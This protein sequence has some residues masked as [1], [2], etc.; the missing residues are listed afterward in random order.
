MK[1]S[2]A[3]LWLLCLS[4]GAGPTLPAAAESQMIRSASGQFSVLAS[5]PTATSASSAFLAESD[6]LRLDPGLLTVSAE[7][8]RQ[9]LVRELHD[10]SPWEG[11]ILFR[12][13]GT[14]SFRAPVEVVAEWQGTGWRYQVSLPEYLARD[15][16]VQALV[17]VDLMEIANRTSA[18]R[19]AEIPAWLTEGL[20]AQLLASR[21]AEL[22][23][24]PP[25]L[26]L[27]GVSATPWVLEQVKYQPLALAHAQLQTNAPLSLEQ[28][29]WPTPESFEGR[30][31]QVYRHC[32]HLLVTRL[33]QLPE[34]PARLHAFIHNLGS[35]YNWQVA[36]LNTY[37]AQFPSLLDFE[38]WW[39]LQVAH[40]TG[41]DLSATYTYSESVQRLREA[42]RFPVEVRLATNTLPMHGE[43]RLQT[44]LEAWDGNRQRRALEQTLTDLALL[45]SRIAPEL[46]ALLDDY[47]LT[48]G[49]YLKQRD[50]AGIYLPKGGNRQASVTLLTRRTLRTLDQL[51]AE[52][53]DL[54]PTP[55]TP[56]A[57]VPSPES[58]PR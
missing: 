35:H 36:F 11:R 51:D 50:R 17:E 40:F 7:R 3:A 19:A 14:D 39:T 53:T 26:N 32:A 41:R 1:A 46:V 58:S 13:R 52:L 54:S 28:L 25:K 24:P 15:R 42:A 21:S 48:L 31:G 22:I 29:S 34:G 18:G 37:P 16:F 4:L 27:R 5:E 45:R 55:Q 44:I 10:R 20:T 8:L 56:P 49:T 30:Q 38:K 57:S 33:L 43:V 2:P 6:L 9:A 47:R 23:L 12:V